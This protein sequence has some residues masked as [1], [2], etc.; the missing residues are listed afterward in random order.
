MVAVLGRRL[1]AVAALRSELE[2]TRLSVLRSGEDGLLDWDGRGDE[3][4][5]LASLELVVE[6]PGE[7]PGRRL[8][9]AVEGETASARRGAE[10]LESVDAVALRAPVR[11]SEVL[12]IRP[13]ELPGRDSVRRWLVFGR[14]SGERFAALVRPLLAIEERFLPESRS[15]LLS[16][17]TGRLGFQTSSRLELALERSSERPAS[18]WPGCGG[19]QPLGRW[20]TGLQFRGRGGWPLGGQIE[21]RRE[22]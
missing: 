21:P 17:P 16:L 6:A 11:E 5:R 20:S 12:A 13:G 19:F 1:G 9:A 10:R 7:A 2:A 8:V 15:P 22:A 3:P 4:G 14:P 18:E